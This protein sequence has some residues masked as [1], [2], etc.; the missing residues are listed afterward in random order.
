GEARQDQQVCGYYPEKWREELQLHTLSRDYGKTSPRRDSGTR[1]A[2]TARPY[3]VQADVGQIAVLEDADGVV[4]RRNVFNLNEK[5]LRFLPIAPFTVRYRFELAHH[6]SY[7][8]AAANSGVPVLLSDDD[9]SELALP[10]P[11]PFFGKHYAKMFLN[12]DGNVTLVE[13]D[14]SSAERSL[15]RMT[16]GPPRIAPLFRDLDPTTGLGSVRVLAEG[17][18]VIVSWVEVREYHDFGAGAAQ[19]FQLRM[20]PDGRIEFSYSGTNTPD[21]VVGISPGGLTGSSSVVSFLNGTSQEYS[22]TIAERF[23]GSEEVDIFTAAQKFYLNHEDSYDFLV[24][25]NGLGVRAGETSVAFEVTVRNNR[26]GFG[27]RKIDI[28]KEAGS[29]R[30]L[31]AIL[32][33]GPLD[34]YPKDANAPLPARASAGDTTLTTLGHE[35]GHLFL[36]YA[37]IRDTTRPDERPMLGFQ[38]A[39]WNFAFNS[40]ASLLEG[41]RIKDNGPGVSP[42][43]TTVATA[44][45]FSPLD[46]YLMGLLPAQ[47]VPDTFLVLNP[48]IG[49]ANRI[50]R[51]GVS[52]DGER[53]NIRID[54]IIQVEG[55]RTPDHTVSQRQFRF[56]FALI[57][58]AGQPPNPE[59]LQQLESYRAQFE[60]F[61]KEAASG[62]AAADTSLKKAIHL[63][64]FPAAGAVEGGV[65]RATVRVDAAPETPLTVLLSSLNGNIG[66]PGSVTIGAGS[67][68]ASFEVGGIRQGIDELTARPAD[69]R[70]ETVT[71]RMQVLRPGS[72][73]LAVISGDRQ[74]A[75]PG[76]PLPAPLEIR[77]TDENEL[78]YA[79]VPV[80]AGVAGGG[81][82][83]PAT[84]VTNER[85]V[86]T[87]QWTPGPNPI[88]ELRASVDGGAVVTATAL[89]Q[90]TFSAA[91]VVNAAS[92]TA[93]LSP[94]AIGTMFGA[95]L[96][97]ASARGSEVLLNGR[98]VQVFYSDTRQV[99]F[100]IPADTPQGEARLAVRTVAGT[101]SEVA[102]RVTATAPGVFFDPASGAGAVLTAGTGRLTT[103]RPA[104]RGEFIEIYA[105]GLGSTR[106]APNGFSETVAEPEVL[107]GGVRARVVFS[108]LT[109]MF[110]GLYQVNAEVPQATGS[111]V[112]PLTVSV[113]GARSNEVR[114]RVQ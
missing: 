21:A 24:L 57:T 43:F 40:E 39:H 70:Y 103:E 72:L 96:A 98:A 89:G 100:L 46:Q 45:G 61:F 12:S 106:R 1:G 83:N 99:N 4:A 22:S 25:F 31:Q 6:N 34:Q 63:S 90:P 107:I 92:F 30:R 109:A 91:T 71:S 102:V 76:T 110:P 37:S 64:T 73:K 112:Q 114:V 86:A 8:L 2:E 36:A 69:P 28:G 41:N 20:Y 67:T 84:A 50:P 18:R 113:N 33:M 23:S 88:N 101:S 105:T 62:K 60:A 3:A 32:N 94:G 9:T 56:A 82:V 29:A 93:G 95:N 26:S 19:T 65:G 15:G 81:S 75:I 79:G 54:E 85:G 87:F 53:R 49:T 44:E 27:D 58:A 48:S 80:Q 13:G 104:A 55:R 10:F 59:Q 14:G 108:G 77:V 38:G 68:E 52:F 35:A 17:G 42:R 5:T 16:A 11:F 74:P 78:P 7:D 97:D 47:E 111:G 66:V 51:V